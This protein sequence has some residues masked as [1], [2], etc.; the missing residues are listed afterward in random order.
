MYITRTV[1]VWSSLINCYKQIRIF[2]KN[3]NK[4]LFI[5]KMEKKQKFNLSHYF[6]LRQNTCKQECRLQSHP[7]A[8]DLSQGPQIENP[9]NINLPGESESWFG[10]TSVGKTYVV[11]C[12]IIWLWNLINIMDDW[13]E[14]REVVVGVHPPPTIIIIV[15][16]TPTMRQTEP[17]FKWFVKSDHPRFCNAYHINWL[18]INSCDTDLTRVL[19]IYFQWWSN[20][21]IASRIWFQKNFR[22]LSTHTNTLSSAAFHEHVTWSVWKLLP[23]IVHWRSCRNGWPTWLWRRC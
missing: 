9:V 5:R 8:I 16:N 15:E 7:L 13:K 11:T 22:R 1:R 12:K 17:S 14:W 3:N 19:F 2:K 10:I 21:W 23:S 18:V 4:V 20:A 6:V